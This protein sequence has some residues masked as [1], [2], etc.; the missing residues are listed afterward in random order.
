MESNRTETKPAR[1][2][3]VFIID[4][5]G[6]MSGLEK[7]T[8]GGFNSVLSQNREVPGECLVT[9]ILFSTDFTVLHD[10][11]PLEQVKDMTLRDYRPGGCTALLDAMGSAIT[12]MLWQEEPGNVQFIIITDGE[13]NSS[14]EYRLSQIREMVTR[15]QTQRGWDFLFLGA[16]MDAIS[17][18]GSLGIRANRAVT[19]HADV[20]GTAVQYEAVS[21]ATVAF[22]CCPSAAVEDESWKQSVEEDSAR[23]R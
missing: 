19:S 10:A 16:N 13:E 18:A 21:E 14:R 15:L 8:V 9:T 1:T 4:R 17:A 11:V 23:R 3:L 5:S 12:R 20:R 22:R 2:Q 7:D 6:S